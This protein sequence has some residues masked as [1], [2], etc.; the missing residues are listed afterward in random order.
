MN[1]IKRKRESKRQVKL[2]FCPFLKHNWCMISCPT[3]VRMCNLYE[4]NRQTNV[5]AVLLSRRFKDYI[6]TV[7]L[8]IRHVYS[9][10]FMAEI[11]KFVSWDIY[12]YDVYWFLSMRHCVGTFS[13]WK[14][15]VTVAIE[16]S[17]LTCEC[18]MTVLSSS[19]WSF[20]I[21]NKIWSM[22]KKVG[23]IELCVT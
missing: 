3:S 1:H 20:G 15:L 16:S 12:S 19:N 9:L 17:K 18:S 4:L 11:E 10:N 23:I 5:Q 6:A 21:E 13:W 22:S 2:R 8:Y 14:S 7:S